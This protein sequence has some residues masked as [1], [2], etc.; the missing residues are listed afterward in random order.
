MLQVTREPSPW[1]SV[2]GTHRDPP[3]VRQRKTFKLHAVCIKD[4][5]KVDLT[6]VMQNGLQFKACQVK[7]EQTSRASNP[8]AAGSLREADSKRKREK[9]VLTVPPQPGRQGP[10]SGNLRV[11]CSPR[12]YC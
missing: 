8:Q 1:G 12:P 11:P 7:H 3:N 9:R 2:T 6:L 5:L 10:A 4:P